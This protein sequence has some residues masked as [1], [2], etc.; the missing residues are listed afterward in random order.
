M[1]RLSGGETAWYFVLACKGLSIHKSV[2]KQVWGTWSTP[3]LC[4]M[5]PSASLPFE[6]CSCTKGGRNSSEQSS[7]F[8]TSKW[9]FAT[10]AVALTRSAHCKM[11]FFII[12]TLLFARLT[13][14]TGI[15]IWRLKMLNLQRTFMSTITTTERYCWKAMRQTIFSLVS[16]VSK[17][18]LLQ[19]SLICLP[20]PWKKL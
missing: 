7:C 20:A 4:E 19:R 1:L 6:S 8:G 15:K 12:F 16:A 11:L 3:S 17:R 13:S 9:D 5:Q 14:S 10:L 2:L 18:W